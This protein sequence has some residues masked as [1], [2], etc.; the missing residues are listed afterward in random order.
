M[1]RSSL[2]TLVPV[3][4]ATAVL[5]LLGWSAGARCARLAA[6]ATY[7]RGAV[8]LAPCR[9][10]LAVLWA[11]LAPALGCGVLTVRWAPVPAVL[12]WFAVTLAACDLTEARL[13]DRL[14]LSAPA[15]LLT[16]LSC[17]AVAT[18]RYGAL[19]SALL[20]SL[21]FGGGYA[22]VRST[23]PRLLG[24]GDVKLAFVLGLPLGAVAPVAVPVVMFAAALLT[25]LAA[26]LT[27]RLRLPHGPAMLLPA[28]LVT[29]S[30]ALLVP[31]RFGG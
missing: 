13:P 31:E 7:E 25:L 20:G 12:G 4:A 9:S 8:R 29:A 27:L 18:G 21:L 30:P 11:S 28:W 10:A 23:R 5:F 24:G 26:G 2:T 19:W 15:P 1:F 6:D 22:L 14:T 16:A 17:W 3:A